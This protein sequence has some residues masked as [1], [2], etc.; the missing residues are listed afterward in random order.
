MKY[1]N[2]TLLNKSQIENLKLQILKLPENEVIETFFNFLDH[3]SFSLNDVESQAVEKF[4]IDKRFQVYIEAI[5]EEL[6]K[7]PEN[8]N[9]EDVLLEAVFDTIKS[10]GWSDLGDIG[11]ILK[12]KN[13]DY[14]K[15][16]NLSEFIN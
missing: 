10:D 4:L 6:Y 11:N 12:E 1:S 16:P 13:I 5:R 8:K 2:I 3:M 7:V 9:K 14:S 15:Y